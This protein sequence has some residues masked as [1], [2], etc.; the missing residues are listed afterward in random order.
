MKKRRGKWIWIA[1][2]LALVVAAAFFGLSWMQ[3]TRVAQMEAAGT[4]EIVSAFIGDLSASATASGQVLAQ[5]D[6]SLALAIPGTVAEV[7]V[8]IGDRV[9]SG[10]PLLVLETAELERAVESAQQALIVQETNL[11]TLLAPPSAADLLAMEAAVASAQANLDDLLD[12]PSQDE[13]IAAEASLRS[14]QASVTSAAARLNALVAGASEEEIRAAEI[15][16]D[17]AQIAATRAA[18]RHSA[19]LVT[20][21]EGRLSEDRLAEMEFS[22]RAAAVQANAALAAAQDA[23]DQLLNGDPN[24]IASAQASLALAT[25]QQ[26]ASQAQFDLVLLGASEAQV[27][28]AEANLAQAKANLDGLQSGPSESQIA[29]GE[30]GVEQSRI[31]LQRAENNLAKATLV[32]PFDGVITAVPISQ[33]EQANGPLIEMVDMNSLE[34]VL[35]VDEVDI[36][37]IAVGQPA[38]ITL[39]SWSEVEIEGEVVSI[40]PRDT[41]GNSALVSYQVYVSLGETE[42][43]VLVGMTAN[44]DLVTTRQ[45]DVLLLPNVAINIDRA[46]GTYSVN[47]VG[48]DAAGNQ[49]IE[50]VEVIVGLRDGDHTQITSGLQAGDQVLVGNAIPVQQFGPGSGDG[51]GRGMMFGGGR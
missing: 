43:P 29:A 41:G 46:T 36:G 15:E 8:E 22:A 23:L 39:E 45:K 50:E 44:A 2:A 34:V 47:R 11:A 12:G 40:A 13:I 31:N 4:G 17:L 38:V 3:N 26:D 7:Y 20:E 18:E 6:A 33:G 16:L 19:I 28:A 37:E 25:A 30:I 9:L 10:E 35:E 24:T 42:L 21:P 5:R 49:T 32:A 1:G 14:V 27:A 48:T 51:G